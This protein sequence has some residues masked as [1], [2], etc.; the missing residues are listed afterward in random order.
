MEQSRLALRYLYVLLAVIMISSCGK[1]EEI[2]PHQIPIEELTTSF[3]QFKKS[4]QEYNADVLKQMV[5]NEGDNFIEL[6]N[7]PMFDSLV[8]GGVLI[9]EIFTPAE[10]RY[11]HYIEEIDRTGGSILLTVRPASM[12]NA[13]EA[14]HYD[15]Q[16]PGLVTYREDELIFDFSDVETNEDIQTAIGLGE[17]ALKWL[18][19]DKITFDYQMQLEGKFYSTSTD[20]YTFFANHGQKTEI[21][22]TNNTLAEENGV[23]LIEYLKSLNDQDQ[24]GVC[25]VLEVVFGKNVTSSLSYPHF[26]ELKLIGFELKQNELTMLANLLDIPLF[27]SKPDTPD[28]NYWKGLLKDIPISDVPII[29]SVEPGSLGVET[30]SYKPLG[31]TPYGTVSFAYFPY[32]SASLKIQ[33]QLILSLANTKPINIVYKPIDID[34]G[35]VIESAIIFSDPSGNEIDFSSYMSEYWNF[36]ATFAGKVIGDM[37]FGMGLGLSYTV[38]IPNVIG[39]TAGFAIVPGVYAEGRV[40][41]GLAIDGLLNGQTDGS[42]LE[43]VYIEGCVDMGVQ[44]QP[45]FFTEIDAIE[46]IWDFQLKLGSPFKYPLLGLLLGQPNEPICYPPQ[47]ESFDI[48]QSEL[49]KIS[50]TQVAVKHILGSDT[51]PNGKYTYA[52]VE[53]NLDD[54]APTVL[55]AFD[56]STYGIQNTDQITDPTIIELLDS[57]SSK[58][59]LQITDISQ[60]CKK[61]FNGFQYFDS[62]CF[63]F[64][65]IQEESTWIPTDFV[66]VDSIEVNATTTLPVQYFSQRDAESYCSS[67]GLRLPR[68]DELT[69]GFDG[70]LNCYP[71]SG[72]IPSGRVKAD[73]LSTAVDRIVDIRNHKNVLVNEFSHSYIW[74]EEEIIGGKDFNLFYYNYDAEESSNDRVFAR[75][76]KSLHAPCLCVL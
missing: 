22:Q 61:T 50:D 12:M 42:F 28:T 15:S 66:L 35:G 23:G 26:T 40:E 58:L 16:L 39:P 53:E 11:M 24:D 34:G 32:H 44:A 2:L 10:K 33:A 9:T 5:L 45:I 25:D 1:D 56:E 18:F 74:M 49:V 30:I 59:K 19:G 52:L 38:G 8:V 37:S 75:D 41:A 67:L 72:F 21:W 14:F 7:D 73:L 69:L 31:T 20:I 70:N 68:F 48:I 60:G 6:Q 3:F 54:I 29:S 76:G 63:A 43:N 51:N 4:T 46:N 62:T 17:D 27:P 64:T 36:D 65:Q 13:F 71:S 47:C 57:G 55:I